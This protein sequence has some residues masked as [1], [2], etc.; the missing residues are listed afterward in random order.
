[1]AQQMSVLGIDI[2]KLVFHVVGMHDSAY[3]QNIRTRLP[4]GGSAS[5]IARASACLPFDS[6][7]YSASLWRAKPEGGGDGLETLTGLYH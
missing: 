5:I 4:T 7:P 6:H 3:G 1:M 2:A